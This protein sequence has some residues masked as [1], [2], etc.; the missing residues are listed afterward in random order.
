MTDL[1]EI[2]ELLNARNRSRFQVRL[3]LSLF[4]RALRRKGA[5]A[6]GAGEGA[7]PDPTRALEKDTHPGA[8]P[9]VRIPLSARS[10][11]LLGAGEAPCQAGAIAKADPPEVG[12][13]QLQQ[14]EVCTCPL[15]RSVWAPRAP[16]TPCM[17]F[18]HD[19]Q[20]KPYA[21]TVH[22]VCNNPA[23]KNSQ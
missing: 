5:A 12:Q 20:H 1:P 19:T 7:E 14:L 3:S 18:H 9:T 10:A 21:V 17:I 23:L 2:T 11:P 16:T 8:G 4:S 22:T 15:A 13:P 6:A